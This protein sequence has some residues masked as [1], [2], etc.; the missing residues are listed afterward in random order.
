MTGE[1]LAIDYAW[2][3][4]Q[5]GA[6]A[7][8][9]YTAVLRY[10]STDPS[11]D[12]S[13]TEAVSL[14]DA[15]L[16][17][18]LIY[19]TTAQRALGS[20][21]AGQEDGAAMLTR[22]QQLGAPTGIPAIANVGDWSVQPEDIGAITAY[23]TAFRRQLGDYVVGAGGYGP[24]GLIK[25]LAVAYP[26]DI[27]WQNAINALGWSGA[28]VH[29]AASIYQRVSAT[30]ALTGAQGS[31]DEDVYGFG[32]RAQLGWWLQPGSTPP[33]VTPPAD[34][35]AQMPTLRQGNTGPAVRTAQGLLLARYYQLG[36]TGPLGDGLDGA[37]GPLTDAAVREAQG[38]A[39]ITVDGIIGPQT[40]PVLAGV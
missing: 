24:G 13:A 34:W 15:H 31:Y 7:Q 33:P 29:P 35:I 12:L 30:R 36:H 38:A 1:L 20:T 19:E 16:G 5:P 8:A 6:I 39:H 40:W 4:P 22:L 11:K 9:G 28:A 17:I 26:G 21:V 23:Y 10:V 25:F 27:W 14:H 2:Q 37:F 32:P 3:H 18:G